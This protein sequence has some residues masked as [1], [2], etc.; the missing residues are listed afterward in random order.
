MVERVDALEIIGIKQ[1]L[2][3]DLLGRFG[4]EIGLKQPQDRRATS[5]G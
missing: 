5:R 1:V 2:R 4:T 3:A